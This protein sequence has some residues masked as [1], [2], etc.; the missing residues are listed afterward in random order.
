MRRMFRSTAP[1]RSAVQPDSAA[2]SVILRSSS[3]AS[4]TTA[5]VDRLRVLVDLAL[6]ELARRALGDVPL[7]EQRERGLARLAAADRRHQ[8]SSS[9]ETSTAVDGHTAHGAERVGDALLHVARDLGQHLA[10]GD[11]ELELDARARRR[12]SRRRDAAR[13]RRTR[14]PS[15]VSAACTTIC[16][17]AA[18]VTFDAGARA[19]SCAR[20][21]RQLRPRLVDERRRVVAASEL[22]AA[23][24]LERDVARRRH[25]LDL[26]LAQ[27]AQRALDRQRARVSSRT[28]TFAI[29][30]S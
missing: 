19:S 12:R 3:A 24:D 5:A 20:Q 13:G 6:V 22:V 18:S 4:R 16:V 25:A 10:V 23:E 7:I 29:S 9:T 8:S 17:T 14:A 15:T 21:R 30:E 1:S 11:G 2:A 26:E 28:I 27:R